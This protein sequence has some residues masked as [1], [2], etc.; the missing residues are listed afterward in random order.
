M[1]ELSN[2][3][4]CDENRAEVPKSISSQEHAKIRQA[5]GSPVHEELG[6]RTLIFTFHFAHSRSVVDAK[7]PSSL[8]APDSAALVYRTQSGA[9][10]LVAIDYIIPPPFST[11]TR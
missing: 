8:V 11:A 4:N 5:V 3:P 9:N 6:E 7:S 2:F 10:S 1:A